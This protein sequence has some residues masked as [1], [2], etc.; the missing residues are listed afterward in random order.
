MK[1]WLENENVKDL[2]DIRDWILGLSDE[3]CKVQH[4]VLRAIAE[5][6]LL[7]IFAGH[8]ERDLLIKSFS[9]IEYDPVVHWDYDVNGQEFPALLRSDEIH[10][11][12]VD[13]VLG[14]S[15]RWRVARYLLDCVTSIVSETTELPQFITPTIG[16]SFLALE[17]DG[18]MLQARWKEAFKCQRAGLVLAGT[19][20]L[21]SFIE[22]LLASAFDEVLSDDERERFGKTKDQHG[23]AIVLHVSKWSL[24]MLLVAA[25]KVLDLRKEH[26]PILRLAQEFRNDVHPMKAKKRKQPLTSADLELVWISAQILVS[27]VGRLVLSRKTKSP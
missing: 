17:A 10:P 18:N 15:F 11:D 27:S 14:N 22:G 25:Q 12:S 13:R 8:P 6:R 20:V 4:E 19:V 3:E 9:A 1:Q 26:W 5:G 2:L 16:L 21:V 24:E 23:N 7:Q